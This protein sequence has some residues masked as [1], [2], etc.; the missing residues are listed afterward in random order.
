MIKSNTVSRPKELYHNGKA[1]RSLNHTEA[2]KDEYLERRRLF[3]LKYQR[4]VDAPT[5]VKED[6]KISMVD[7]A[8]T[9][10]LYD[11]IRFYLYKRRGTYANN[12]MI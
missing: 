8:K 2:D 9:T 10:E 11:R 5:I 3:W 6:F 1:G 12:R 7:F 4:A